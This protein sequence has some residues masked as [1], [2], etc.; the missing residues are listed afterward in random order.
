MRILISSPFWGAYR[1]F[2]IHNRD[3]SQFFGY[4]FQSTPKT[5]P[6]YSRFPYVKHNLSPALAFQKSCAPP[7]HGGF[8]GRKHLTGWQLSAQLRM[9]L[10]GLP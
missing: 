4:N 3:A 7:R 10:P 5:V 2:A 9:L 8:T 6:D 1:L